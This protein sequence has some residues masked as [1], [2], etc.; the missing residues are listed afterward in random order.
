MILA[1]GP[2]L[3]R[4]NKSL[5]VWKPPPRL[6]VSEWSEAHRILSSESSARAGMF[7]L[8]LAPYQEEPMNSVHD[9]VVQSVCLMW[10]SQTGKTEC[11]NNIVGYFMSQDPSPML[12]LQ[13]TLDMAETWSKDRLSPMIR[14]TPTLKGLVSDPKTRESG[15]TMLHKRFLGGHI[16]IAGANSPASLAARP[17]RVLLC[18]EVD[19]YPASAGSEGDPVSLAERRT[20][21]FPNAVIIKTSTPT[22]KDL[23]KV[24]NEYLQSDQRKWFV[25]CPKCD[26]FQV[27][28]FRHIIFEKE[29]PEDATLR[30]EHCK[31]EL[32]DEDRVKMVGLGEWRPTAEFIG[33]RGYWLNGMNSIFPPKRGFKN[34]LHQAVAGFLESKRRGTEGLKTWVNTFCAEPWEEVD[35]VIEGH[36][37]MARREVYEELPPEVLLLTAGVDVQA[38][39]LECEVVGWGVDE[40]SWGVEY[41]VIYGDPS[42]PHVWNDLDEH[43]TA[44]WPTEDG[45]ELTV[46]ACC[47]DSGY[48]T[49]SVYDYVAKYQFR[50]VYAVKGVGGFGKPLVARPTK[51]S[52]RE[53][54]LFI[55]GTDTAKDTLYSRLKIRDTGFG[56]CHFPSTYDEKY[57]DQLT[58]EKCVIETKRGQR[59]R[60]WIVKE[61]FRNEALDVRNYAMAAMIILNPNWTRLR[62]KAE[63]KDDASESGD[64]EKTR[65][66]SKL[67]PLPRHRGAK[68][69]FI[70]SWRG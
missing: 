64:E 49:K 32:T 58:S 53:V 14:D 17:I 21:T 29:K 62:F 68:G 56:Y 43:L 46:A 20:D 42:Q 54:R 31:K 27:L 33:K 67:A 61:G 10:A 3:A 24:E 23:S 63:K 15:N 9:P 36:F 11:V 41:R 65:S 66:R 30:C 13:P 28:T 37:L 4:L 47:I 39:R 50:G 60:K 22:I 34:R 16:T 69:G 44:R 45:R 7:R 51:S 55:I 52:V 1:F 25:P 59:V 57:F 38:D 70:G 12:C 26:E 2:T 6:T 5:S 18:D 48:L 40:E 35:D 8:T 19:R